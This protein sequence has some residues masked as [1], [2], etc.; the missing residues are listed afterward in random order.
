MMSREPLNLYSPVIQWVTVSLMLILQ[1][2]LG[3]RSQSID[4]KNA[5]A[6]A[7]IPSGGPVLIEMSRYFNSDGGKYE[8]VIRLKKSLYCQ[9]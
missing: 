9:A 2:M 4:L 6:K 5:F 8:G 1:F 3:F 7:D